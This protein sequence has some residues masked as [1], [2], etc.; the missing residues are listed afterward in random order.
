VGVGLQ[1]VPIFR[2]SLPKRQVA[3]R[4][5]GVEWRISSSAGFSQVVRG[6]S[7]KPQGS[8]AELVKLQ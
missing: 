5:L 7:P 8:H 6:A 1:Q 4:A 2:K 3:G